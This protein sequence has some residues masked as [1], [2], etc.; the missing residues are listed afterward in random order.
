[1]CHLLVQYED[2]SVWMCVHRSVIHDIVTHNGTL[3]C[4]NNNTIALI[5]ISGWLC[6]YSFFI[7][8]MTRQQL[9]IRK[10]KTQRDIALCL[11]AWKYCLLYHLYLVLEL[12]WNYPL[13]KVEIY[14][15]PSNANTLLISRYWS[16]RHTA[17]FC[18]GLFS[19]NFDH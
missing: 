17:T 5:Y 1:M 4:C 8:L 9:Y 12:F 7:I 16:M 6:A 3:P 10:C 18:L 13:D 15:L 14:E 2:L 19:I 11:F